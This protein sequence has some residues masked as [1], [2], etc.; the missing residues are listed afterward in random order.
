VAVTIAQQTYITFTMSYGLYLLIG[1]AVC[2]S[3][4]A[5]FPE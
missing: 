2:Y 3:K 1:D 5:E 4:L